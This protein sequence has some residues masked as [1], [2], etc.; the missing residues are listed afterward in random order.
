MVLFCGQGMTTLVEVYDSGDPTSAPNYLALVDCG[1][2]VAE[3]QTATTYIADKVAAKADKKLDAVLISHQDQDH[4][5]LLDQLGKKLA[6][7]GCTGERI[8]VGGISW[9]KHNQAKVKRF[10]KTLGIPAK[11]VGFDAPFS[12]DY[13]D[14]DKRTDLGYWAKYQ[15]VYIR[16]LVSGLSVTGKD[17]IVKNS[18]SAVLVVENGAYSMVLPGDATY[19]TMEAA[20]DILDVKNLIPKVIGLE[21]PHHGALRTAVED[22]Y[23][24]GKPKDFDFSIINSF[25]ANIA[26]Q[27]VVASAGPRN[28]HNHPMEEVLQVFESTLGTAGAHGYVAYEFKAAEWWNYGD[29]KKDLY[30]T[31]R[32][33]HGGDYTW[34]DVSIQLTADGL[35]RP[36]E[37]VRFIPRGRFGAGGW[38]DEPV[39]Y[40]PAPPGAS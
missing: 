17:D 22:Y 34:G 2:N 19:Q 35:L 11:K 3:G 21:I 16:V 15:N 28:T 7:K 38:D 4:V 39:Y 30:C 25:A 18:S 8:F 32:T 36:E 27:V 6:A 29:V 20:N 13:E 14:V 9:E 23:A 37:M 31:V 12:S 26:P 5:L 40:A 24:K 33:L 1:G 10:V